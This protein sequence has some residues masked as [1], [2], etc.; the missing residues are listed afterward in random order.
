MPEPW[1]DVMQVCLNGHKTAEG[2]KTWP[3]HGKQFCSNCG[4][5]T[6]SKCQ[7]CQKD[8]PGF[9]HAPF[10]I[11]DAVV[12]VFC[13]SCGKPY[14]W[15]ESKLK[16][17]QELAQEVEGLSDSERDALK[18]SLDDLVR[19]TPRTGLAATRFKRLVAKSGKGTAEAFKT[20]LIDVLV[21]TAKRVIF[22]T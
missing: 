5:A 13:Q 7:N 3:Q 18:A 10:N 8:I 22:P 9:Y 19:D 6:I 4:A 14:P 15:T 11:A 20:I 2:L 12:P 1:F 17:A 21:E 16:A